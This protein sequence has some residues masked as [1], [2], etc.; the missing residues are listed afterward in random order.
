MILQGQI[1]TFFTE[2]GFFGT[3]LNNYGHNNDDDNS[4]CDCYGAKCFSYIIKFILKLSNEP[5]SVIIPIVQ[6]NKEVFK[7][8]CNLTK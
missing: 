2:H 1:L 8:F 3:F 5:D 6:M 7:W 4:N